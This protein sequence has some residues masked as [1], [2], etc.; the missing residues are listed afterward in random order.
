MED[1][2]CGVQPSREQ[3]VKALDQQTTWMPFIAGIATH[4]F[5]IQAV[6]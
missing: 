3:A 5:R 1:A 4:S 6:T 2:Y